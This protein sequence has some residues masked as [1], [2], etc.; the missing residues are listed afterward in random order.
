MDEEEAENAQ[1]ASAIPASGH[2]QKHGWTSGSKRW[3]SMPNIDASKPL[4]RWCSDTDQPLLQIVI[5]MLLSHC[6]GWC[7]GA[8]KPLL[9]MVQ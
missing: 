8:S 4:F 1:T 5:L 3:P 6:C 9:Q 7:S 2:T